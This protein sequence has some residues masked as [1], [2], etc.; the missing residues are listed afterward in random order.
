MD[1]RNR[2]WKA[3]KYWGPPFIRRSPINGQSNERMSLLVT[4]HYH[5][6]NRWIDSTVTSS[7]GF[8]LELCVRLGWLRSYPTTGFREDWFL[9]SKMSLNQDQL[10]LDDFK[11][12]VEDFKRRPLVRLA[13][14]AERHQAVGRLGRVVRAEQDFALLQILDDL[15][16][17][18]PVVGLK[19]KAEDFPPEIRVWRHLCSLMTLNHCKRSHL[20]ILHNF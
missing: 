5:R 6:K 20:I 19:S 2:E 14:P 8:A 3:R 11:F 9:A 16:M 7:N 17:R 12:S 13:V 10:A 15:F 18:H 4:S 1:N